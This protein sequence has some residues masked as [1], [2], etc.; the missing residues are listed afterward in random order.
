[1]SQSALDSAKSLVQAES[2][3]IITERVNSILANDP[4]LSNGDAFLVLSELN[5][6]SSSDGAQGMVY[7]GNGW[8]K[9]NSD[10]ETLVSL[11]LE[12]GTLQEATAA[13]H[14]KNNKTESKLNVVNGG[15][16]KR[17]D[18]LGEEILNSYAATDNLKIEQVVYERLQ[19]FEQRGGADRIEHVN[20]EVET[21]KR[22]E[23]GLQ[24]KYGS[25]IVEKRRLMMK[26]KASTD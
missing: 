3:N 1:M 9:A 25:L 5:R 2:S 26:L 13:L 8:S 10:G 21:L 19:S 20:K 7:N 15:Y 6:R 16:V 12:L 24:E 14:K 17:S 11:R 23:A 4:T 22:E 18:K